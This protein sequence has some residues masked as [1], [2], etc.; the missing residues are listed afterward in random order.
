V[1]AWGSLCRDVPD[2]FINTVVPGHVDGKCTNIFTCPT[3]FHLIQ[4]YQLF[5]NLLYF[6]C[7]HINVFAIK[8]DI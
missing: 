3:N 5:L 2:I 8:I 7:L 1:D 6:T 4:N